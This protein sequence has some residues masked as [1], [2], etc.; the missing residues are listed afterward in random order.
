M[1]FPQEVRIIASCRF[2]KL[3]PK[4]WAVVPT[5]TQLP[6]KSGSDAIDLRGRQCCYDSCYAGRHSECQTRSMRLSPGRA[7]G[8][9]QNLSDEKRRLV[10]TEPCNRYIGPD[11][12]PA[13]SNA[14]PPLRVFE[15]QIEKQHR[16]TTRSLTG[17]RIELL[18]QLPEFADH[19]AALA[20]A[21]NMR[22]SGKHFHTARIKALRRRQ[23]L[24]TG[25]P[26]LLNLASA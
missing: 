19:I 17:L 6:S 13:I 14:A 18:P 24:H 20:C 11:G 3:S 25:P 5:R 10:A 26:N 2:Q 23:H 12:H 21:R 7:S 4:R 1:G 16:A 15:V 22:R 9:C 8:L